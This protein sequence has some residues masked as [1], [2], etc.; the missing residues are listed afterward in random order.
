MQKLLITTL[1]PDFS[2]LVT[3]SK[4]TIFFLDTLPLHRKRTPQTRHTF[5]A[6]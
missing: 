5:Q 1:V 3:D 2:K 4:A 6:V